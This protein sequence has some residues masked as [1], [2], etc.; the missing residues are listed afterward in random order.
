MEKP[1]HKLLEAALQ[2]AGR[3]W[4]VFPVP[5]DCAKRSLLAAEFADRRKWGQ[6]CDPAEIERIWLRIRRTRG[7][8]I[9]VACGEQSGIF[10]VEADTKEGHDVDGLANLERA[11]AVM[12]PL[13]PTLMAELPS[14][15]VH[16]IYRHP[17]HKVCSRNGKFYLPTGEHLP[18]IDVKGDGGM[19]VAPPSVRNGVAYRWVNDLP[20]ADAPFWL[21]DIVCGDLPGDRPRGSR[22][23][24]ARPD[25]G[26]ARPLTPTPSW[27]A[28]HSEDAGKGL[29]HDELDLPFSARECAA[30]ILALADVERGLEGGRLPFDDWWRIFPPIRRY[31][32]GPAPDWLL[33]ICEARAYHGTRKGTSPERILED[34][35]SQANATEIGLGTLYHIATTYAPNWR[36]YMGPEL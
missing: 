10:D 12:G 2:Y 22:P 35:W 21:I 16:R 24:S 11:Q 5:H 23:K 17:G 33:P 31:V 13:T 1:T 30:I 20:I 26:V 8:N 28:D 9:G 14:G 36:D 7:A 4:R 25:L 27:L 6:T 32:P 3:G 18:G 29:S 15:S 34:A 19:F